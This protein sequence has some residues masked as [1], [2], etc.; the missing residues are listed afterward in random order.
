LVKEENME[1]IIT[2][3]GLAMLILEG[4]KLIIRKIKKQPDFDFPVIF[5]TI[6]LPVLNA[7]TPFVLFWLGISVDSTVLGMEWLDLLKYI[8]VI[9][10]GSLVSVGTYTVS[11]KPMKVYNERLELEKESVG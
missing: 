9:M 3:G 10:L 8:V 4:I 7:L 6:S 5:Y 11:L 2:A 1:E